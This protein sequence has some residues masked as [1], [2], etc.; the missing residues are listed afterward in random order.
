MHC[1]DADEFLDSSSYN[2]TPTVIGG[3][4]TTPSPSVFSVAGKFDGAGDGVKY[5]SHAAFQFG[6]GDFAIDLRFRTNTT[7]GTHVLFDFRD[8]TNPGPYLRQNGRHLIY[9]D[10]LTDRIGFFDFLQ[11]NTW[12]H[13]VILRKSGVTQ[14]FID[15]VRV[16][17]RFPDSSNYTCGSFIFF[18]IDKDGSSNSINGY[19]DEVRVSKGTDRGWGNSGFTPPAAGFSA[20]LARAQALIMG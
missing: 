19:L 5:P 12:Y 11:S 2:H 18:A 14:M 20:G 7:S 13:I 15:G 3:A 4:Q 10:G 17:D 1:D 9:S 16:G 8:G 6:T